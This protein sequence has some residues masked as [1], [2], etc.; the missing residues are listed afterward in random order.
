VSGGHEEI[1][2]FLLNEGAKDTINSIDANG[3]TL[4]HHAARSGK[5]ELLVKL[6]ALGLEPMTK[7]RFGNTPLHIAAGGGH[8]EIVQLLHDKW[9]NMPDCTIDA[10]PESGRTPL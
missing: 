4:L 9:K 1:V 10:R 5:Y 7:D 2:E 8:L 6:L 3:W